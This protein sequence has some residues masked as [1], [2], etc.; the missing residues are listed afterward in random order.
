MVID[1]LSV[2]ETN[3]AEQAAYVAAEK[4]ERV[5]RASLEWVLADI[6]ADIEAA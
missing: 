6:M 3:R 4:D 5:Q 2:V 1:F